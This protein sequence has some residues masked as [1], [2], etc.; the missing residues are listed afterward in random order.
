MGADH[1]LLAVEGA[2]AEEGRE[3]APR[4]PEGQVGLGEV[5]QVALV[6]EEAEA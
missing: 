1:Q 4:R 2:G 6:L 3:D 5:A